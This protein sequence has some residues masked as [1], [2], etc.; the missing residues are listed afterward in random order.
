MTG[1]AVGSGDIHTYAVDLWVEDADLLCDAPA[2]RT[3]LEDAAA[4]GE[5]TVL[6][7]HAHVFPNGA[8]TVFLILAQSHLSLHTWPEFHLANV[9]LFSY[10]PIR[11][12][13]V[14]E[15]VRRR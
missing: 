1:Q 5:A 13:R 6:G 2:L 14:V 3:M 8:V 15:E 10:G 9:D 4:A 11:G 12:D 7:G